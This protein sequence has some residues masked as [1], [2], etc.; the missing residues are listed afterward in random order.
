[1][2]KTTI[3][4]IIQFL[5]NL[6]IDNGLSVDSIALFGSALRGEMHEDSDIDLIII[7][8]DFINK[9]IFE[10]SQMTMKPEIETL[11]K[12]KVSMDILNL[13]PEEY[14][15]SKLNRYYDSK[16]VA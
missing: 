9:D 8:S 1:M 3:N 13:S 14:A 11:K 2:D 15:D 7:S 16:I 10:R 4:E 6:L 5:K 12:Y